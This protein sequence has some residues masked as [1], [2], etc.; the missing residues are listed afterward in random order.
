MFRS[1]AELLLYYYSRGDLS[2][3]FSAN[4]RAF[5]FS[6]QP[7]PSPIFEGSE[8]G[9]SGRARSAQARSLLFGWGAAMARRVQERRGLR[10]YS[11][12]NSYSWGPLHE[13]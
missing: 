8:P 5:P 6:L 10:N 4:F 2:I 3:A 11:G 9:Q 7:H 1:L 13:F 12:L